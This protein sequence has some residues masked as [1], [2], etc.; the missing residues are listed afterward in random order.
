MVTT[1]RA[2]IHNGNLVPGEKLNLPEGREVELTIIEIPS[3]EDVDKSR[4]AAGGW[5]DLVDAEN[6]IRN[7]YRDRLVRT[8]LRPR[9]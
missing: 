7:I 8:R 9:L 2:T 6:L 4:R 5:K 1:M 3:E